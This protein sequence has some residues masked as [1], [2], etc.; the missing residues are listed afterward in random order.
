ML[1]EDINPSNQEKLY[2]KDI[3]FPDDINMPRGF[4]PVMRLSYGNHARQAAFEEKYGVLNLP[5]VVDVRKVNIFEVGVTGKTVTKLAFRMP[6][7]E[8]N[9]IVIVVT[10]H[11]GFVKTVWANRKTD[12][13]KTLDRSKYSDPKR[14]R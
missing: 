12:T 1:L 5:Q 4:N 3:G 14:S 7:D 2:H 8:L 11:N 6:H 13:H 10:P 9:D